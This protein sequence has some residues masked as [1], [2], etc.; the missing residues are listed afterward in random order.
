MSDGENRVLEFAFPGPSR[1]GLVAAVLSG[2]KTATSSLLVEWEVENE[3]L[4][5]IGERQTVV[6]SAGDPVGVIEIL[7]VD[8]IRLGDA[9]SALAF[10]EGEGYASVAEWRTAH[11]QF[12]RDEIFRRF[13]GQATPLGDDTQVVVERFRLVG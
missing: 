6:D 7:A 4:P 2:E 1:D 12:W 13:P 10:D 3:P 11:E 9:D 5:T 8:V